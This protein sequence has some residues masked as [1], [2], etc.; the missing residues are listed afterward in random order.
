M[1]ALWFSTPATLHFRGCANI[2]ISPSRL[3]TVAYSAI[4]AGTCR[5]VNNHKASDGNM[6]VEEAMENRVKPYN[7]GR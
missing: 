5:C 3:Y 4:A 6:G 7:E 1:V 2:T